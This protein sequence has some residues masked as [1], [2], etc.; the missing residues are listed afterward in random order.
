MF[1]VFI[2]GLGAVL[3]VAGA[4]YRAAQAEAA[5]PPVGAFV[6]V[7][8]GQVHYVQQGQGPHLIL[9]H[10]AGGNLREFTFD[11]MGRLSQR[12]TVTAFDR[13]GLGYTD[14]VPGI[15]K[16][17]AATAG[18]SPQAQAAMLREAAA[19]LGITDPIIAGHSFGG[20]VAYAWAVAGLDADSPVNAR[21]IVSLAGVTMPWPG[22]LGSYYTINGSAFGGLVT[23]PLIS[24]LVPNGVIDSRIEDTFTPQAAPTGYARHIGAALTLRPA[25]FRANIRQVNTSWPHVAALSRRYP[26]LSLPVEMV[27]GTAD[28][29]V[30]IHIHADPGVKILPNAHLV[31]LDGIG[32]MPHHTNPDETVAAIDRAAAH[33]GLVPRR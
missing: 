7:T 19:A 3:T 27:H 30:P 33:A 21:A 12:Y 22:G 23:V 2:I 29:T 10:G 4:Q 8:G 24:A 32:H 18:D 1:T 14:R 6:S 11:L 25:S 13:P 28:T 5:Y 15:A 9:L 26:E 20:I 31:R 17:A 16:G